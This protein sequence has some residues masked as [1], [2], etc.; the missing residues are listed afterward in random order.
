VIDRFLSHLWIHTFAPITHKGGFFMRKITTLVVAGVFA[1]GMAGCSPYM[2][3]EP[4]DENLF[5]EAIAAA[6]EAKA[7]NE[8]AQD[9]AS[10]AEAAAKLAEQSA[11]SAERSARAASG[12]A[13][14]AKSAAD[15]ATKAFEMTL[16][17]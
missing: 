16:Q 9:A 12:S 15:K 11:Q 8:S 7:A 5:N 17:K 14:E 2:T 6:R 13:S 10:R 4:E 1:A 3:I